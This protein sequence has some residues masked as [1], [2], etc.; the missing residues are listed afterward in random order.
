MI[1]CEGCAGSRK[2]PGCKGSGKCAQCGGTGSV[3]DNCPHCGN[4]GQLRC[5]ECTSQWGINDSPGECQE[6][7]G[8]GDCLECEEES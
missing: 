1:T 7:D 6:C 2:C 8:S 4:L 5:D 3:E